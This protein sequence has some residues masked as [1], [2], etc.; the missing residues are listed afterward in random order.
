MV[1]CCFANIQNKY[2]TDKIFQNTRKSKIIHQKAYDTLFEIIIFIF[3]KSQFFFV[4]Y[5]FVSY[6]L[7]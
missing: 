1:Y 7:F 3:V 2:A 5:I 4:L 6:E